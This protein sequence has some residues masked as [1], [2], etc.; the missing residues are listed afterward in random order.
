VD[1]PKA[2]T[3]GG[4]AP[5]ANPIVERSRSLRRTMTEP[6]IILWSCL[7]K[8]RAQGVRFRRQAP[9]R[10]YYLDF[11]CYE[12]RLVIEVDGGY[13]GEDDQEARDQFRDFVVRGQ[14]FMVLRVWNHEVRENLDGVMYSI[15]IAVGLIEQS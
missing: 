11:V 1:R 4:T 12:H 6:E 7:K 5:A 9:F 3:G 13:H 2:E 10:G 15:M 14:G 8:L